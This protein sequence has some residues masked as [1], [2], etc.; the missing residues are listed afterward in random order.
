MKK[1][2]KW[3]LK[4]MKIEV[5]E[6]YGNRKEITRTIIKFDDQRNYYIYKTNRKGYEGKVLSCWCATMEHW[7]KEK[8]SQSNGDCIRSMENDDLAKALAK[9]ISSYVGEDELIS[10]QPIKEWLDLH[11]GES[12]STMKKVQVI[13]CGEN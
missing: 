11:A 3:E 9:L 13:D 1:L 8:V 2:Y 6:T 7:A 12:R 10:I 5:G 4:M